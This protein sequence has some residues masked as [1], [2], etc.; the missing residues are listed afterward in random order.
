MGNRLRLAFGLPGIA[1]LFPLAEQYNTTSGMI[2]NLTSKY[3]LSMWS[4]FIIDTFEAGVSSY[5]V[6]ELK[7][8]YPPQC[9]Y[10]V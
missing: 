2:N 3:V 7:C 1:S 4:S 8:R 9:P 5:W 6:F 10:N